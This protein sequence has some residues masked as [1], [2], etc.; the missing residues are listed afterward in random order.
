MRPFDKETNTGPLLCTRVACQI[1]G[2]ARAQIYDKKGPRSKFGHVGGGANQLTWNLFWAA[3]APANGFDTRE[4]AK[5][6]HA[7][8]RGRF[9]TAAVEIHDKKWPQVKSRL[10]GRINFA[11]SRPYS[12]PTFK[13]NF[14]KFSPL[15][16]FCSVSGNVSNP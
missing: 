4:F 3:F 12:S 16:N 14:P 6:C 9:D 8:N 15:Y 5:I 10:S 11:P 2:L 1:C 7:R 13:I